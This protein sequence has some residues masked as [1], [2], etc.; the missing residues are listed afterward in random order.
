[1]KGE[2]VKR[3]LISL[4]L[5]AAACS[6]RD[7]APPRSGAA[8]DSTMTPLAE[9]YVR[10]VLALGE[11][12]ANYVD[13]YYGPEAWRTEVK[14]EKPSLDSIAARAQALRTELEPIDVTGSDEL[15]RLRKDYLLTQLGSLQAYVR[16]LKGERLKFD[17]ESR[18][19]VRCRGAHPSGVALPVDPGQ[20][21]RRV[22][23]CRS[24]AGPAGAL[25]TA[26]RHSRRKNSTRYSRLPSR[27]RAGAPPRSCKC[28]PKS[29]SRWNT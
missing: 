26:F 6:P 18:A 29:R 19:L 11:H 2:L 1:M 3:L 14:A 27:K 10:L 12:D 17:E 16:M 9:R 5:L 7:A 20:P 28:R 24:R 8:L 21:Q 22:A 25:Q 4:I 23:G 13:A 15:Q